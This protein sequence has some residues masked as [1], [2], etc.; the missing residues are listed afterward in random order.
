[1]LEGWFEAR[2]GLGQDCKDEFIR[3]LEDCVLFGT[4]YTPWQVMLKS[5]HA[6][7]GRF[8]EL[9]L[10]EEILTRLAGFQQQAVQ[11]FIALLKRHWGVMLCDSVGLGKTYE[12]MGVLREFANQRSGDSS[13]QAP[14]TRALI[15]CSAQLQD[16]WSSNRLSEWGIFAETVTMES[17]PSFADIADESVQIAQELARNK[18]QYYQNNFDIILVDESHNFRNPRTKRY[19]ALMDIIRGGKP[20]TRVLLMTATPI[21]N[22]I[23][24]LYHQLM[25]ITRGYD[26][27]YAGRGPILNL[28]AAFQAIEDGDSSSTLLDLMML[29]LVRRT[30]HDIRAM[31]AAGEE[32]EINGQPLRFPDHEIPK[33]IQYSLEGLYGGIYKDI[34][35]AIESLNF[36]VYR[37]DEYGVEPGERT[38]EARLRQRNAN[39][40]GVM[41]TIL[42]KRME[43]SLAA[44]TSTVKTLVDYLGLFLKPT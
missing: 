9:G 5:L 25:L 15:V 23:W 7:Y 21:N 34:I 26:T 44:L 37:L 1:M 40:V 29:F 18:L 17:L 36:A 16:N 11:R 12:G 8:L 42:L 35:S 19:R 32:M 13:N 4:R 31:Q 14:T 30:R 43:S 38:S 3:R 6:A 28:K 41:R 27:W 2:W 10:S 39:F 33:P 24:D 22:S 20:D